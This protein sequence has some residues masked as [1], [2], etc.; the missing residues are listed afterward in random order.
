[1][2]KT[3]TAVA[4]LALSA[5]LAMAGHGHGKHHGNKQGDAGWSEK[6][7]QKLNL[8]EAQKQQVADLQKQFRAGNEPFL[9]SLRQ[10]KT[11]YHAA[12]EAGDT[13]RAEALRATL[14]SQKAELKQRNKTQHE[15][16]VAL[17]SPE[18]RAQLEAMKAERGERHEKRQ[19]RE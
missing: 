12:R 5:S 16:I 14:D 9:S 18:Q 7:A 4:A 8:S 2:K 3:I 6:F 15:R 13:A 10:T 11:D 19:N 17:L 1:M